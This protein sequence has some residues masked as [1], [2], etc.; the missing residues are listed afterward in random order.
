MGQPINVIMLVR[1][2]QHFIFLFDN[3]NRHGVLRQLAQFAADPEIQFSWRDAAMIGLKCREVT[4]ANK[5]R[6]FTK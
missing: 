5:Y 4:S 2:K 1:G 3:K 6:R